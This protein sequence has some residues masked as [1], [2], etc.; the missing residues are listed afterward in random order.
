MNVILRWCIK[1]VTSHC[2]VNCD[3]CMF[4]IILSGLFMLIEPGIS[5]ASHGL[6]LC[7]G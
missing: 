3:T 1:V 7:L 4:V 2:F 6:V 5:V